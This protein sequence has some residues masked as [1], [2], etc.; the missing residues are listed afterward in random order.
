MRRPPPD[1]PFAEQSR[2]ID[3]R[4]HRW[5]VQQIGDGPDLL[6]LHGAGAS[7]HSWR[8]LAPLLAPHVRVTMIDL[9][10][11]GFT[12]L[13]TRARAGLDPVS[14]DIA[15]LLRTLSVKPAAIVGH[16]AGA[17]V[18]LRLAL[19]L[20]GQTPVIAIN[21]AFQMFGGIAGVLF[22][23]VAKALAL[24]PLTAPLFAAAGSPA[25]TK[26]MLA[27]TGSVIDAA[28]LRQYHALISDRT[29]VEGALSMMA[30]WSLDRLVRDSARLNAPVLLLVGEKDG[31]VPPSVSRDMETRLLDVRMTV[32]GGKGHLL[33]EEAPDEVAEA[34]LAFLNETILSDR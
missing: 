19:D 11:H 7:T 8:A 34:V 26:R 29:H 13:G 12:R 10:G 17:A 1:W 27:G 3:A 22:P 20:P 18:A 4:P 33:H 14:E 25:R 28:G 21:G 32:F 16:S 9:P 31:T 5:H 6:L 24:N 15:T 2:F 23:L 30:S